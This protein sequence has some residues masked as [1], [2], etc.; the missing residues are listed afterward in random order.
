MSLFKKIKSGLFLLAG[1]CVIE[2]EKMLLHTAD[3]LKEITEDAGV[4]FVFKS[5]FDKA[6][7][8]SVDSFR[9]PGIDKGLDLLSEVKKKLNVKIVTDVHIPEEV[10][11]ASEV[12]DI[13]QIPAFL[14]RQTDLLLAAGRTNRIVNVKK[15]QFMSPES[16]K[17]I[18]KKL[19]SAGCREIMITERG[20]SFGPGR[21]VVDFSG[22]GV[23]KKFG[24]PI[25]FDATHS[26]QTPPVGD[27]ITGG[28]REAIE[29]LLYAAVSAGVDGIYMEVH[30]RPEK[31]LCD[32]GS[33]WP[34]D[35]VKEVLDKALRIYRVIH[36]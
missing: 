35:K 20:S 27:S 15:G 26:V 34:L 21:L 32:K 31:A 5:S 9:G 8:T 14:C 17:N 19:E 13:I 33:Q 2:N 4:P 25:I 23:L 12:A 22:I 30:P 16:V 10:G 36:G 11:K 28:K 6:N 24:Y 18:I 29:D 3:R 1:P 7:R